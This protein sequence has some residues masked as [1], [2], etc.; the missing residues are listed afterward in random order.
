MTQTCTRL[1]PATCTKSP[2]AM[3][4][5]VSG[6]ELFTTAQEKGPVGTLGCQLLTTTTWLVTDEG[7]TAKLDISNV[8]SLVDNPTACAD[9]EKQMKAQ[10]PNMLG[11]EGCT[12]T[13]KIGLAK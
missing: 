10:S 11:V 8:L 1:D 6:S 13:F 9:V 7:S 5:M 3:T 2:D 4:F 12:M